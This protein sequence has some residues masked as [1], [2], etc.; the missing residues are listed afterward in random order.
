MAYRCNSRLVVRNY[1]RLDCGSTVA[2]FINLVCPGISQH[3][4]NSVPDSNPRRTLR[5][6]ISRFYCNRVQRPLS[7]REKEIIQRLCFALQNKSVQLS[8]YSRKALAGSFQELNRLFCSM[9][10]LPM[11]GLVEPIPVQVGAL[12]LESLFSFELQ[13]LIAENSCKNDIETF[14]HG[15][16]SAPTD[17]PARYHSSWCAAPSGGD[18]NGGLC[19]DVAQSA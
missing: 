4:L 10:G 19:S 8:E 12:P 1:H 18:K 11:D 13:N 17:V 2:D 16:V 3:A 15:L 9:T 7:R 14:V 6:D 5:N